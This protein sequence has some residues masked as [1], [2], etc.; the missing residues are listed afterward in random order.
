MDFP[1]GEVSNN[2]STVPV[3][4]Y[5]ILYKWNGKLIIF[6]DSAHVFDGDYRSALWKNIFEGNDLRGTTVY[7]PDVRDA[8]DVTGKLSER[9]LYN[10]I[11][12][13]G[14]GEISRQKRYELEAGGS[15]RAVKDK[16][17]KDIGSL[18]F[19]NKSVDF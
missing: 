8:D 10:P 3:A 19:K 6:D 11:S 7:H 5:N 17:F 2:G 18:F 12:M 13:E 16:F 14:E 15:S 9:G 1:S 4:L